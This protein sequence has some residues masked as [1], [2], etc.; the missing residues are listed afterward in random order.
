MRVAD[1]L[2]T[3]FD[4][5]D[6]NDDHQEEACHDEKDESPDDPG[7]WPTSGDVALIRRLVDVVKMEAK[8]LPDERRAHLT[9]DAGSGSTESPIRD[10][11]SRHRLSPGRAGNR[12][13]PV[14]D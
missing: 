8:P 14:G 10:R 6:N 1:P 12:S 3:Q 5:A 13:P 2:T 11:R 9:P 4:P 7:H